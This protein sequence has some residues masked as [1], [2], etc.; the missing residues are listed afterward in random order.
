MK[1]SRLIDWNNQIYIGE[2]TQNQNLEGYVNALSDVVESYGKNR[3]CSVWVCTDTFGFGKGYNHTYEVKGFGLYDTDV[4]AY[5]NRAFR[6][7]GIDS[8]IRLWQNFNNIPTGGFF[9]ASRFVDCLKEK[10]NNTK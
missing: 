4:F 10:L 2:H 6:N 1:N 7:A 3:T 9:E 5:V 8:E